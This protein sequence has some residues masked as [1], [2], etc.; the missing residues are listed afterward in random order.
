M[1]G[2]NI[3]KTNCKLKSGSVSL[4]FTIINNSHTYLWSSSFFIKGKK[5]YLNMRK[6]ILNIYRSGTTLIH[7]DAQWILVSSFHWLCG[8]TNIRLQKIIWIDVKTVTLLFYHVQACENYYLI[9]LRKNR[10]ISFSWKR[11]Y[12]Y[13][14][15]FKIMINPLVYGI[16][17][18]PYYQV[19]KQ[20]TN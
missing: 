6:S 16:Y 10:K 19:F 14:H 12:N 3:T 2:Y 9:R 15:S 17:F 5:E 4:D 11:S 13:I 8:E 1:R 18:E 7:L 20:K